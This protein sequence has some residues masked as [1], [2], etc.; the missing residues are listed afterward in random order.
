M[1]AVPY[2]WNAFAY[3]GWPL[4]ATAFYFSKNTM[5]S[6]TGGFC[7]K[8]GRYDSFVTWSAELLFPRANYN[9]RVE[10]RRLKKKC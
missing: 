3:L 9:R 7:E 4:S 5:E 10:E 2:L 6:R 1:C 8:S